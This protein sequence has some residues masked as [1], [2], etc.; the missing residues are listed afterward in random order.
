LGIA[1]EQLDLPP[2]GVAIEAEIVGV[3]RPDQVAAGQGDAL[4][5]RVAIAAPL[6]VADDPHAFIAGELIEH[7]KPYWREIGVRR[8]RW[9]SWTRPTA[10]RRASLWRRRRTRERSHG[11]TSG[12]DSLLCVPCH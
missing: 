1:L 9:P 2:H 5:V 10:G 4:V 11:R 12:D 6:L 7:A 3:E 8:R